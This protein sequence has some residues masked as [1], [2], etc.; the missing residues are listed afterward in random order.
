MW[1]PALQMTNGPAGPFAA[2]DFVRFGFES[3][4]S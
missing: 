4:E 2:I 3:A 1:L